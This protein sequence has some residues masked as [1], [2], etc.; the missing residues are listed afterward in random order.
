MGYRLESPVHSWRWE[1]GQLYEIIGLR[2]SWG[3][4]PKGKLCFNF[5]KRGDDAGCH[6]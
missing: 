3:L 6:S 1:W 5:R 4:F 2:L